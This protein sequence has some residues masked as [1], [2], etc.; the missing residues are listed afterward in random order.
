MAA[1]CDRPVAAAASRDWAI[2]SALRS[3]TPNQITGM[4]LPCARSFISRRNDRLEQ[5]RRRDQLA[6]VIIEEVADPA[7]GLQLGNIAVEIQPTGP[8]RRYL[9]SRTRP[10]CLRQSPPPDRTL[11]APALTWPL[12]P[13]QYRFHGPDDELASSCAATGTRNL[14]VRGAASLDE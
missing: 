1:T 11:G 4:P 13:P 8:G 3:P 5:H 6:L 14:A 12:W 9:M 7:K 10:P 2:T